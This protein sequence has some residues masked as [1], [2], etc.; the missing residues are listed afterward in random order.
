MKLS[1]RETRRMELLI[2]QLSAFDDDFLIFH[3]LIL[4]EISQAENPERPLLP[5]SRLS[6][7]IMSDADCLFNFRFK[8]DEIVRLTNCLQIPEV[9]IT[10]MGRYKFLAVEAMCLV[11]RRLTWSCRWRDLLPMFGR[12]EGALS[13]VFTDVTGFLVTKW[14]QILYFDSGRIFPLLV[15]FAGAI[16]AAGSPLDNCWGFVDGTLRPCARPSRH[17]RVVYNG[18]K[19]VHGLKYQGIITPD[20]LFSHFFG[21]YEGRRHDIT[22]LRESK[23]EEITTEARNLGYYVYGDPAYRSRNGFISPYDSAALTPDQQTFNQKMSSVRVAVEWG[24]GIILNQWRFLDC[25]REQ[26]LLLSP[27]ANWYLTAVL[28]TNC[29]TC[30]RQGNEISDTFHLQ[31]PS[32][33]SYLH[34]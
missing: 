6:L 8:R 2:L 27:I 34:D 4:Q 29:Q 23:V 15:Q 30:V 11:L 1:S 33:E 9:I 17:Q 26:K 19:R 28:L 20:G 24:F 14:K 13:A 10:T 32:L 18:H 3:P 31:P 12:S 5:A 25:K 21:P 16:H 22:V 7:D